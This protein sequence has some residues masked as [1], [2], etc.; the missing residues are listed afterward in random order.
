MWGGALS[1]APPLRVS[2]GPSTRL[3]L[4]R[5]SRAGDRFDLLK[6]GR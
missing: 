1:A 3:S 4:T 5:L 6:N 2:T